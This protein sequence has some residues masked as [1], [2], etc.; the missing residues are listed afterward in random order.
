VIMGFEMKDTRLLFDSENAVEKGT[1]PAVVCIM[2][3][4]EE[5]RRG[6]TSFL[7]LLCTS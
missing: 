5:R 7:P 3:I 4:D 1:G 6:T 2:I